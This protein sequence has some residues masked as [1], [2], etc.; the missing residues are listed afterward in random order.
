M[1]VFRDY[2]AHAPQGNGPAILVVAIAV[3]VV[4]IG[5][6]LAQSFLAVPP[7]FEPPLIIALTQR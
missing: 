6:A 3:H 7:I 4:V 2:G 5:G 1:S